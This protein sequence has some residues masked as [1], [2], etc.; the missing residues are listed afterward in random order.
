MRIKRIPPG[1]RKAEP[2]DIL[3]KRIEINPTRMPPIEFVP[4]RRISRRTLLL[5][6]F[7]LI[8]VLGVAI[9]PF[10]GS[11]A[12]LIVLFVAGIALGSGSTYLIMTREEE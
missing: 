9:S 5:V 7:F 12:K 3:S 8:A 1:W 2:G 11:P 10:V 6:I 4:I